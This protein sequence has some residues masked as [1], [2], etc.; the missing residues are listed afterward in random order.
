LLKVKREGAEK[1]IKSI[2]RIKEGLKR[3]S[4]KQGYVHNAALYELEPK[5]H[6][7]CDDPAKYFAK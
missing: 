5:N 6:K 4:K 3:K 1:M 2:R 7:K